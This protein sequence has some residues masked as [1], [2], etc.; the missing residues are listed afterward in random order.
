M[1]LDLNFTSILKVFVMPTSDELTAQ[2]PIQ[3]FLDDILDNDYIHGL[4]N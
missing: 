3:G 1:H 4:F 2:S